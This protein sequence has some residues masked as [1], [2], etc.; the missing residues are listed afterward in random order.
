MAIDTSIK[1][2]LVEDA[3]TMR[4]MEA[5][6]LGQVG[7]NNIVEAVD[8]QD[9]VAK[10]EAGEEVGLVISDWSMPNMDG[11]E[12]VQWLRGQEKFN[13]IP[14]LM[15]TGHGDKEYVAKA[16]EG[17]ANGVVAKPFTPAELQSAIEKAFGLE[18]EEAPKVDEGPKVSSEGKVHLKLAHIQ[19]TDHLALGVL[20]HWIDTGRETPVHFTLETKCMGSW[21]PVQGALESSEVDG[22]F[23]LAPAAMDLF[24]YDVPL[25]L[26]LFAHRNGSICVR[27]RQGKYIKPYQQF[28]KHKTFYIPHKMSIHNML[29]H[30]YFTQMGLKPGVA[31]KEAVNV[32]FDVAPPVAMPQFLKDNPEASG[33]LVAE[34]IGSRAIAA[35]IAEKQFLSSEIWE[36]HPCCVVV[37]RDE[38]IDQYPEAVQEFTDLVVKAGRSIKQDI[39]QSAQI[40]VHFLDPEKSIGLEPALLKNVLSDP[41]GIVYDDLYP[42]KED[43]ETIQDYMVN[44]MEI[45][46]TIDLNTFIDTRFAAKACGSDADRSAAREGGQRSGAL[47]LEEFKEKQQLTSREGKY[48]VFSLGSERYG[49]GIL[50]VKEIIGLMEIHELPHMPSF[51]KGVI[52]LRDRV[53]PVMDLRLKFGM[54]SAAYNERTCIIIVEISGVR[55]STLTGIIV[56]SVSEVVNVKDDQVED[57][58]SF[59]TGVD[60]NMIL[61][62]AKLKEGVTI[63]LDID[64]LMHTQEVVE[65]GAVE[66]MF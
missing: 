57:A 21:N 12:L 18:Q 28:F 30:M 42:V 65:L 19:I 16:I 54:E 11:L 55:G 23:I 33:F 47:K 7:F 53:I 15:A 5:K 51:F 35:G 56:D 20:K 59:G 4:K 1:I 9:A 27:N 32:L 41:A 13:D 25:K 52:N 61:G 29:A 43:L 2:L 39:D 44:K 17:G 26:V 34:P 63:L 66:E 10:L 36:Q 46:R 8:G 50:D 45:G 3:G 14:F 6:I 38:I 24:S 58:P 64:R 22:A 48:L 49:I 37:F 40:A 31:G 62:M 60:Q